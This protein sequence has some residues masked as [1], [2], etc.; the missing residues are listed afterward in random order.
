MA[1]AHPT[2]MVHAGDAPQLPAPQLPPVGRR[3][4]PLLSA[5]LATIRN[6]FRPQN[7]EPLPWKGT[8]QRAERFRA[9]FALIHHENGDEACI[10]CRICEKICPSE[11]ITVTSSGRVDNRV[12][13][14]QKKRGYADDFTLDLNA[15][16]VC[17]LC[18]QVCPEDAIIM[19][20]EREPAGFSRE[21]LVLTMDKLYANEKKDAL[22]WGRGSVFNAEQ[23]PKRPPRKPPEPAPDPTPEAAPEEEPS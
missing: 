10:G 14:T 21:A 15:C 20:K 9:T 23:D 22:A 18:V 5:L 4:W 2:E 3:G 16:L 12:D 7:T 1:D 8:R 11:V 19:L 13:P 6:I 17:E